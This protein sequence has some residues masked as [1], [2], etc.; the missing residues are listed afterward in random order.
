M[1]QP[2]LHLAAER[3]LVIS[4]GN[5]QLTLIFHSGGSKDCSVSRGKP[6]LEADPYM[7]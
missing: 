3:A 1:G 7:K 2:V 6:S 5:Y 4:N